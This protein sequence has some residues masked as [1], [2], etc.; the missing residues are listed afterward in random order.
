VKMVNVCC[1]VI[2]CVFIHEIFAMDEYQKK[3]PSRIYIPLARPLRKEE[4]S[5]LV[6][7]AILYKCG[8]KWYKK[9]ILGEE[10][11]GYNSYQVYLA[12]SDGKSYKSGVCAKID[13]LFAI[14]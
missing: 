3:A 1:V 11:V 8:D 4:M 6:G 13:E 5:D 10:V 7:K 14:Q 9:A 12:R 2:S